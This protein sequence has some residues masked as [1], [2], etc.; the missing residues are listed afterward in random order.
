M[1]AIGKTFANHGEQF[2]VVL[3]GHDHYI[4]TSL[5]DKRAWRFSYIE[6][7]EILNGCRL[8]V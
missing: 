1:T 8:E 7:A 3:K 5:R 2:I 4:C 6:I